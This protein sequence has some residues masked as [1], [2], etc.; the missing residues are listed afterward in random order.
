MIQRLSFKCQIKSM[1]YTIFIFYK[2][3]FLHF[4]KKIFRINQKKR[5]QK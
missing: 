2:D 3:I 5:P 1:K 4:N